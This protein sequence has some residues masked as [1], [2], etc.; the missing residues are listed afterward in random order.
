M[1]R[2][3]S[4]ETNRLRISEDISRFP[5]HLRFWMWV[6][7]AC[8]LV[9]KAAAQPP[10]CPKLADLSGAWEDS[11]AKTDLLIAPDRIVVGDKFVHVAL[12]LEEKP[13]H[14]T[15]RERG[16]RKA[17]DLERAPQ[18][19]SLH[20]DSTTLHFTRL[21]AVPESMQLRP[22]VLGT[23]APVSKEKAEEIGSSLLSRAKADQQALK[24][25][26]EARNKI[27]QENREYLLKLLAEYGWIDIDRFGKYPSSAALLIAK[28]SS[29]MPLSMTVL[30]IAEKDARAHSALGEMISVLYDQVNLMLGQKQ[31]YGTQI[32]DDAEGHGVV[33]PV[34][35]RTKVDE[36]R[37]QLGI[38]T[39]ADYLSQ[40]SQALYD[41][42]PIR[43][44]GDDE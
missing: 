21:A 34:E 27:L 31:R 40:A 26:A 30:P 9:S 37:K 4:S 14:V 19:F 10:S 29:D 43:I 15:V 44:A 36:Y 42:K 3:N 7:L 13:C 6:V 32:I 25:P 11:A 5:K 20:K 33:L 2:R 16:L 18:G 24:G 17:W 28:H 1:I 41:G 8:A 12:V 22:V 23:A 35:D 39:W 38:P